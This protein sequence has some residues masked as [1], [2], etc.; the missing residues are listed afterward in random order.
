MAK[1]NNDNMDGYLNDHPEFYE[2]YLNKRMDKA[3][4]EQAMDSFWDEYPEGIDEGDKSPHKG[5]TDAIFPKIF[6]K[7]WKENGYLPK[8]SNLA[9]FYLKGVEPTA[10]ERN[11][12]NWD[13]SASKSGQSSMA[14]VGG[15]DNVNGA[16]YK[17]Y[18]NLGQ[19][20]TVEEVE[21]FQPAGRSIS[22]G[23]R[24]G[25]KY[26]TPTF[27]EIANQLNRLYKMA[28]GAMGRSLN[29][30]DDFRDTREELLN[31][32]EAAQTAAETLIGTEE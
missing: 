32:I 26:S 16:A 8:E 17:Y 3:S 13:D 12:M 19:K 15:P 5:L 24:S 6:K 4:W 23:S 30:D 18:H 10:E 28:M 2:A 9:R 14:G 11:D 27:E 22:S 31:S 25:S 7:F 29:N 20:P 21:N 1:P